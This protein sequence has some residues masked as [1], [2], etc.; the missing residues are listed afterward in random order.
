MKRALRRHRQLKV[1]IRRLR[2][3]WNI[4]GGYGREQLLE[5]PWECLNHYHHWVW[6]TPSSWT[7]QFMTRPAR[8]KTQALLRQ[9][10]REV[11]DP[12]GINWPDYHRPHIYFW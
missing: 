7:N 8:A 2:Y 1:R 10:E 3:L 5:R 12:D 9:V 11:I 4:S 6:S